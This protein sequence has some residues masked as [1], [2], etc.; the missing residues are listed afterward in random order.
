MR[1]KKWLATCINR[2]LGRNTTGRA[3]SRCSPRGQRVRLFCEELETR[4]APAVAIPL[5]TLSDPAATANDSFGNSVAVS[6]SNVLIGAIGVNGYKGAAYLYSTSGQLLQTFTDPNNTA[7]DAFGQSVAISGTNVLIGAY[8]PNNTGTGAA[9]LY[10]TSGGSPLQTFTDPN[11]TAN[12]NFGY[13]VGLSGSNVLVGA[14]DVNGERGAAYLFS[15][16]GGSPLQTFTDPNNTANDL[17]GVSVALSGSNV[18]V[19]AD[20]VNGGN[21]AAY[22]YSTSGQLLQT[23]TDPNN[24]GINVFGSSVA[25][26]GSNVLVGGYGLNGSKGAAY[27]YSTSG[28]SPLQTFT[29]PNNTENDNFGSSVMLSGSNV[30]IGADGVTSSKGAAYLY[31]TSGGSPLQTFTDPNNTAND[32]FGRVALSGS[33]V[34]VGASGVNGSEGAAYG[35][36]TASAVSALVGN[37]QSTSV[38]TAFSTQLEVQVTD[39]FGNLLPAASVTFTESTGASGAGATFAGGSTATTI[40]TNAQGVAI[41][42]PLTANNAAGSFTVT[43]TLGSLSTTFVLT[44]TSGAPASV[45]IAGGSSQSTPI[46]SAF[47]TLLQALVTDSHNNPVANVPVTFA[48]PN[49]GPSGTFNALATVLT[50][51]QGIA[52]APTLSVNFQPGSFTATAT[53]AG[54]GAANY[55]LTNTLIPAV[56]KAAVGSGQHATVSTAFT[57]ALQ[58]RVTNAAGQPVGGI[59]VTFVVPGSGASG[60]FATLATVVTNASGIATA[61]ALT[62]N[63]LV[64]SFTVDA[65][66]AGVVKPAPFTLTNKADP[67]LDP[68]AG[69]P[70]SATVGQG[71]AQPLTG[72]VSDALGR[73]LG[74]IP[75][76]FTA[77]AHGASGTFS[78]K[79]SVTVLTGTNGVAIAPAFTANTRAGRFVV[80]E[81][82]PGVPPTSVTLTNLAGPAAQVTAVAGSTRTAPIDGTFRTLEVQVT[83]AFGNVLSGLQVTFTV[84]TNASSGAGGAFNGQ[85]TATATTNGDGVA[86]APRFRANAHRGTFTVTAAVAGVAETVTFDLTI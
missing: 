46:G 55:S 16:S 38:G 48:A 86:A 17:F 44:N 56:I 54:L 28:G 45:S 10:S 74:G 21:G 43:A 11:N 66:V 29:D 73:P 57:L 5:L 68:V 82:A 9:Y 2:I 58:A 77:P 51:A 85:A 23:F 34:L 37:N 65:W 39:V 64:G 32:Y 67:P 80:T 52:T 36:Q 60:T 50:N 76:T 63:S 4:L 49:S 15:T 75:V 78:G 24:T 41:A 61:P 70:Q 81:S 47:S 22:L 18:L 53:V 72:R 25:V 31:S 8:G 62:A 42:P 33:N 14:I 19:G 79:R 84:Q 69:P 35:Y 20:E 30:L 71:Y 6:G 40:A 83:D 26:S 3:S 7:N 1:L 27:L 12:D 13:S 59:T